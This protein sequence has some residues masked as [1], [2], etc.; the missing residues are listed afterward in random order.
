LLK[1]W[2]AEQLFAEREARGKAAQST[3]PTWAPGSKAW[4]LRNRWFLSGRTDRRE[5]HRQPL[6]LVSSQRFERQLEL[7]GVG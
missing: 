6:C 3:Q 4:G 5:K 2:G 7:L 1:R